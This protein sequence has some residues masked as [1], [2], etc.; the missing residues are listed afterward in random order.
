LPQYRH[1]RPH[2]LPEQLRS[3]PHLFPALHL[4][5]LPATHLALLAA[6]RLAV[7]PAIQREARLAAHNLAAHNLVARHGEILAKTGS[8]LVNPQMRGRH[9]MFF[10]L[11]RVQSF[12]RV[13]VL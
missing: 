12:D 5:L 4:V 6:Y 7:S 8:H 11:L 3:S 2:R 13:P 9:R 1:P 10:L